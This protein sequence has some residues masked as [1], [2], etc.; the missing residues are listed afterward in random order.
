M[1]KFYVEFDLLKG[2]ILE[3]LK[4]EEGLGTIEIAIIIIILIGLALLFKGT[5]TT[6]LESLLSQFTW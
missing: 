1:T 4:D 6:F 3:A 2:R 5:I